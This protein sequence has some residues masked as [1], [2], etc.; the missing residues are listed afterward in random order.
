MGISPPFLEIG[1]EDL[2]AIEP[3][4]LLP[5]S[6]HG[7]HSL[8]QLLPRPLRLLPLVPL[9]LHRLDAIPRPT[10]LLLQFL[11]L[12]LQRP[13]LLLPSFHIKLSL[14]RLRLEI[15]EGFFESY[16]ELFFGKE[17]FFHLLDVGV[18]FFEVSVVLGD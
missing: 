7:P 15:D 17:M 13:Y 1:Q 14:V 9:L 10:P 12:I 6:F 4:L 16:G 8:L 11:I 18:F 3:S 2:K 5:L